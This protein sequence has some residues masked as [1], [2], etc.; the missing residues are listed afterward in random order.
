M[1]GF[2]VGECRFSTNGCGQPNRVVCTRTWSL[3]TYISYVTLCIFFFIFFKK[4]WLEK[5]SYSYRGKIGVGAFT[6]SFFFLIRSNLGRPGGQTTQID[7]ECGKW[8]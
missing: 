2:L 7:R 3:A 1:I 8:A 4:I 5:P 6:F